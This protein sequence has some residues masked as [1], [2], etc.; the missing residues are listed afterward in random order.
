MPKVSVIMPA[1]NVEKYISASVN[2]V[3]YQTLRDIELILVN[4][5]SVDNTAKIIRKIADSDNRVIFVDNKENRGAAAARN[6]GIERATGEWLYFMDSDDIID[7]DAF[8]NLLDLDGADDVDIIIFKKYGGKTN[9]GNVQR[10]NRPVP[11]NI[12]EPGPMTKLYKRKLILDNGLRYQNLSSCNDVFFTFMAMVSAKSAIKVDKQYYHYNHTN[13]SAISANRASKAY[14]LFE[15]FDAMKSEME[16]LGLFENYEQ[17]FNNVFASCVRYEL[18]NMTSRAQQSEFE[19]R[20]LNLYPAVHKKL[21]RFKKIFHKMRFVDGRRDIYLFGIKIFS[22]TRKHK[23]NLPHI[24]KNKLNRKIEKFNSIGT[25]VE[26]GRNPR[27]I[28]SL[29]SFPARIHEIHFTIYSLLT[30]SLKPDMVVLWLGVEEFPNRENDLP[31]SL[32]QL[33]N[34][35]LTIKWCNDIKSYKKLLP[36]LKEYP[37]DIIITVDDDIFYLRD[38]V[39]NLYTAYCK[40]PQYIHCLRAHRV[41]F[42]LNGNIKPYNS[43]EKCIKHVKPSYENFFTG[44]GGVLYPPH[45]FSDEIFNQDVFMKLAPRADDVWFW[46]MAVINHVQVNVVDSGFYL[47]YISPERDLGLNDE[48]TLWSLNKLADGN[49]LQIAA[50]LKYYNIT[51]QNIEA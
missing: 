42:G 45:I 20:L 11:M 14:N 47:I 39:K 4:D 44:V 31:D 12:T 37:D 17:Q 36:A 6:I 5:G 26:S 27:I 41:A 16:K 21:F 10:F 51:Q 19:S 25:D 35:G 38:T 40:N 28:V 48:P 22:Y 2:S 1:Y 29:T 23:I 33:R 34:N 8:E 32:L 43:W 7:S 50:V 13:P 49:D 15:A 9:T 24:D 46:A 3:L 18:S 30:Q